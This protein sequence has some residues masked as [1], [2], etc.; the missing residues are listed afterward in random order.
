M[1]SV[2][3]S[4]LRFAYIRVQDLNRISEWMGNSPEVCRKH[5][6]EIRN[7][8]VRSDVISAF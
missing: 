4:I 6:V 5:Y 1:N 3:G 2:P 7:T 8:K